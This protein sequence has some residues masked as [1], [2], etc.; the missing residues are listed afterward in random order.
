VRDSGDAAFEAS[1]RK[2]LAALDALREPANKA[3]L[4]KREALRKYVEATGETPDIPALG[5]ILDA[6]SGEPRKRSRASVAFEN[7]MLREF[8]EWG[9]GRGIATVLDVTIPRAREYLASLYAP[10]KPRYTAS[11]TRSV[12]GILAR[13]FDRVLPEGTANPF[14]HPTLRV[15]AT[16]GD[17]TQH[18][19]P[20][21]PDEVEKLL[22]T[23]A[24]VDAEAHDWMVCA[25][26]T[27][28]RRGDICRLR[29]DAVDTEAG[30]LRVR[31]H[32][33]GVELHLPIMPGLADVLA[34]RKGIAAGDGVLV[35]P[36]AAALYEG[37]ES[38]ITRRVKKIFALAFSK[39]PGAHMKADIASVT[40]KKR[41]IGKRAASVRD[42]HS[43][44]TTFVTLAISA[45]VSVD[46][47]RALT[48]HATVDLVMRHYFRP[49][50]TDFAEELEKALPDILTKSSPRGEMKKD[51]ASA[52]KTG[53]RKS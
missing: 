11:T 52:D 35:F 25:L 17:S 4:T 5:S 6:R 12:K 49:K 40:Q 31:T 13:A 26:S 14:R 19:E 44:R 7:A 47:L 8:A 22:H 1:R 2:A 45:G 36:E 3:R 37:N 32:K 30:A 28:L 43:L 41:T 16:E 48:G 46:K 9:Q 42:F 39:E 29:W 23:A 15:V 18:R 34:R 24:K 38:A 27:G 33:T 53:K 21:R 50:G 20:L 51:N 10:P